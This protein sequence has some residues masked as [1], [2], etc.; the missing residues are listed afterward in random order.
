MISSKSLMVNQ[1][2]TNLIL[3]QNAVVVPLAGH[4]KR[5]QASHF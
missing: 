2:E 4:K 1:K 5:Q 3:P